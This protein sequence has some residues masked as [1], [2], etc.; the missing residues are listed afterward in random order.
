MSDDG[1]LNFDDVRAETQRAL[2]QV[3]ENADELWKEEAYA[4]VARTARLL[5]EYISDDVWSVGRL[6][7][8][9]ETGLSARSSSAPSGTA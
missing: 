9:R 7:S 2:K 4:A 1:Q 6:T 8:T 5:P 3:E